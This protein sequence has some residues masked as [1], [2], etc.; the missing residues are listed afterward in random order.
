MISV[1]NL[2][3]ISTEQLSSLPPGPPVRSPDG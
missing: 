3:N 2:Y 1:I